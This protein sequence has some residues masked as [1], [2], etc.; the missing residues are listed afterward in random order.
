VLPKRTKL[1]PNPH[2]PSRL[3][4]KRQRLH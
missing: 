4:F 3:R 1:W 2:R